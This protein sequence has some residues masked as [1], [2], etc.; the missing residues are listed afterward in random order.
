MPNY[1]LPVMAGLREKG[2]S[3]FLLFN[4]FRGSNEVLGNNIKYFLHANFLFPK[5][6]MISVAVASIELH[7][8]P[9]ALLFKTFFF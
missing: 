2:Q 3:S 7:S 5:L 8:L 9:Y 4:Q 6:K 1:N